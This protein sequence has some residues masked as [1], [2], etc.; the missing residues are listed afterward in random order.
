M[1]PPIVQNVTAILNATVVI[2]PNVKPVQVT[3]V[4]VTLV[5]NVTVFDDK[6]DKKDK[7]DK[8]KGDSFI[9]GSLNGPFKPIDKKEER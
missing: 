1:P 2:E 9:L 8:D 6:K 5:N 3:R 4:N 7:K